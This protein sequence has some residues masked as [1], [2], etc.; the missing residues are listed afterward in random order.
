MTT[1][2]VDMQ[3]VGGVFIDA[4]ASVLRELSNDSKDNV[5][6]MVRYLA[7]ELRVHAF[8]TTD[9]LNAIVD[10]VFSDEIHYDFLFSLQYQF[11]AKWGRD[12]IGVSTLSGVLALSISHPF[13][14]GEQSILPSVYGERFNTEDIMKQL[15][16]QNRWLTMILLMRLYVDTSKLQVQTQQ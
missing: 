15:F 9:G 4:Y 5:A 12:Q 1:E 6:S 10:Y 13:A 3:E 16:D 11:F 7:A 2:A 14:N 8:L